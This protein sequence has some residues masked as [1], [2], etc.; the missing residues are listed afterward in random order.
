MARRKRH[1][2]ANNSFH[3]EVWRVG[4][5]ST[6]VRDSAAERAGDVWRGRGEQVGGGA[7][8]SV[9]GLTT[10]WTGLARSQPFIF[11][12]IARPLIRVRDLLYLKS[13]FCQQKLVCPSVRF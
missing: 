2:G 8:E 7:G 5:I 12:V 4:R 10:H 1:E 6:G 9:R 3:Q 13:H 11:D